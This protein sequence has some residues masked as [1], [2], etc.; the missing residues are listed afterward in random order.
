MRLPADGASR[1]T[2]SGDAG[3]RRCFCPGSGHEPRQHRCR[4]RGRFAHARV[5][6]RGSRPSGASDTCSQPC[7]PWLAFPPALAAAR[8]RVR[9]GRGLTSQNSWTAASLRRCFRARVSD[10]QS[11]CKRP[12]PISRLKLNRPS[13]RSQRRRR[14][15]GEACSGRKTELCRAARETHRGIRRFAWLTCLQGGGEGGRASSWSQSATS[16]TSL[17]CSPCSVHDEAQGRL[18]GRG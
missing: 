15:V 10:S 4:D 13:D 2:R 8:S 3:E 12:W 7:A 1:S 9:T 11:P 16:A 17:T 14:G 6:R 18:F 5:V